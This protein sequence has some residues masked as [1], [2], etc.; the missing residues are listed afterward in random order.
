MEL[1]PVQKL[2][3]VLHR[4]NAAQ[5][6]HFRTGN[7]IV[8]ELKNK[9]ITIESKEL[10]EILHKLHED[11]TCYKNIHQ[12]NTTYYYSTFE[13]QLLESRGGYEGRFIVEQAYA[14]ELKREKQR[15]I[16]V[17]E[18]SAI[19]QER[20]NIQTSRLIYAGWAAALG[21]GFLGLMEI[22]KLIMGTLK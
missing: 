14:D 5:K 15:V 9:G 6:P 13:G 18:E 16:R 12:D 21:T 7:E 4:I 2:D 3:E 8:I 19:R 10:F 17:D 22:I 1:T 20:L 11:K